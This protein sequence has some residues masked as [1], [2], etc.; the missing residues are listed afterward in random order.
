MTLEEIK[1][2]VSPIPSFITD[3]DLACYYKYANLLKEGSLII[4]L[5]TGWG[6]SMLALALSSSRNVVFSCDS[7]HYP[8]YMKWAEDTTSYEEQIDK[9]IQE[10]GLEKRVSFY[11]QTAEEF[12][13]LL[14]APS[15]VHID[16]WAEINN[17]D[18]NFLLSKWIDKLRVGG[19]LLCR[20]YGRGDRE[21]WTASVDRATAKMTRIEQMGLITI[22][23]K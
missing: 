18:S 14:L 5:G 23:Q 21:G 19:Y 12:V 11:L 3:D 1:T 17:T 8:I 22:F 6:K 10:H 16:N 20:N 15:L 13:E 7:G 4:D 9:L 2:A